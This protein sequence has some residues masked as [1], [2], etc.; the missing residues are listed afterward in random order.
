MHLYIKLWFKTKKVP[1]F[2]RVL[3]NH[4]KCVTDFASDAQAKSYSLVT[5]L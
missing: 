3:Q 5:T 2:L 4:L 1:L